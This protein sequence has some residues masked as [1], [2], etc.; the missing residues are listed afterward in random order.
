[1]SMG[2]GG[3]I[4][5]MTPCTKIACSSHS[6]SRRRTSRKAA[7]IAR[8]S[9]TATP[10][11]PR[12]SHDSTSRCTMQSLAS[13]SCSVERR[14]ARHLGQPHAGGG[15][16]AVHRGGHQVDQPEAP[17][18]HLHA[19]D[20]EGGHAAFVGPVAVAVYGHVTNP[21][22]VGGHVDVERGNRVGQVS[23]VASQSLGGGDLDLEIDTPTDV[24]L[25]GAQVLS[26]FAT[27]FRLPSG[28]STARGPSSLPRSGSIAVGGATRRQRP[29]AARWPGRRGARHLRA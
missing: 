14:P 6:T 13:H 11:P 23:S 15:L 22:G 19:L 2:G 9:S 3:P 21:I 20:D 26:S 17:V 12:F 1:M 27:T 4:G 28:T 16:P 5:E 10:T 8:Q 29:W 7:A 25:I 24:D 18:D